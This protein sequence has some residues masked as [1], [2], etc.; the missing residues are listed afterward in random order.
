MNFSLIIMTEV[1]FIDKMH[2]K[3]LQ[4]VDAILFIFSKIHIYMILVKINTINKTATKIHC[5]TK[6]IL[7]DVDILRD[8]ED[9]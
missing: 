2:L 5:I 8:F 6:F 1:L 3:I 7:R 9:N 4:Y